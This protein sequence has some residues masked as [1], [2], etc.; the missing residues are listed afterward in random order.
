MSSR[1]L[2]KSERPPKGYNVHM[3]WYT[4]KERRWVARYLGVLLGHYNTREGAVAAVFEDIPIRRTF[5]GVRW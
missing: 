4:M 3:E 5:Y 1:T 2:G